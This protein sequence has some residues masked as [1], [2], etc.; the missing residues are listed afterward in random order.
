[1]D[2]TGN[3]W[4]WTSSLYRPYPYEATD[5]RE[6]PITGD[7]RRVV[8]GGSWGYYQVLARPAY[9]LRSD[10]DDRGGNVGVR[11]VCSSPIF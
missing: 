4:D 7:G 5:G 1:V 11:L 8:R 3:V 6:N 10:P 9:R 2:M